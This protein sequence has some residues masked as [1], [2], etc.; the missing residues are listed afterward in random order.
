MAAV[1][2]AAANL[3]WRAAFPSLMGQP[4]PQAIDTTSVWLASALPVLLGS[5]IYL[6]LARSFA[7]ATPL[8][9]LGS[10]AVA[11]A[12]CVATMTPTLPDGSPAPPGFMSLT[13]PMHMMAGFAAAIVTPLVVVAGRR[14]A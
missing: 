9:V 6:L 12:S 5:G 8:Y 1:L 10:I 11:G 4:V 13:I 2:A 7:I 14:R 3:G